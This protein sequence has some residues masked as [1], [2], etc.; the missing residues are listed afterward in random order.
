MVSTALAGTLV[1]FIFTMLD[2]HVIAWQALTRPIVLGPFVG[3]VLG[4]FK[5]GIILGA[6][7]EAI[8]MGISSIGA[9]IPSD[10]GTATVV[11]VSAVIKSGLDT[12]AALALA[13]PIGT[14]AVSIKNL[15]NPVW[16][17]TAP[18]FEKLAAE[19]KINR[20]ILDSY[21]VSTGQALSR[22]IPMFLAVAFGV[23]GL[24]NLLNSLPAW[25]MTGISATGGLMRG[26]GFAIL[27]SLIWSNNLGIFFFVGYVLA[28]FLGLGTLPIA[29][30]GG[31]I[32]LT[33]F[34]RDK[35]MKEML[36]R[37]ANASADDGGF[38]A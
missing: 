23:E 29:I 11:V 2:P 27:V 13:V 15:F 33:M 25:V 26:V 24:T 4:D 20:I 3:L 28:K 6:S 34:F 37:N 30:L 31:A 35:E 12:E 1:Y 22:A 16:A 10:P 14:I 36:K 38:L 18:H 19:G 17:A 9:Q 7:L 21:L 8:F 5:T 32:A